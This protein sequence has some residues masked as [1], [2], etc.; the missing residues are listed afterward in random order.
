MSQLQYEDRIFIASEKLGLRELFRTSGP[1]ILNLPNKTPNTSE[2]PGLP[3]VMT[4]VCSRRAADHRNFVYA[5]VG[6]TSARDDPL[7]LIDYS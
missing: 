3:E 6:L 4:L 2:F 1:R 7:M 5:L